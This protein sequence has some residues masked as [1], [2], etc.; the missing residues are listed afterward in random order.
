MDDLQELISGVRRFR[1]DQGLPPRREIALALLDADSLVEGWAEDLLVALGAV[2]VDRIPAEREHGHTRV[3]AGSLQ[4]FIPLDG[5]I[6]LDAERSR[7]DKAIGQVEADQ[8]RAQGK[9]SNASFLDRAP[10]EVVEKERRKLD[11]ATELLEALRAQR[12]AL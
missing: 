12:S 5:L 10:T 7:L 1:A 3:V 11:E 6:D 9:L 8:K 2:T 4:G